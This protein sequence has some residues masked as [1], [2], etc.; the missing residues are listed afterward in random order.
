MK[1][2]R[3]ASNEIPAD[4]EVDVLMQTILKEW[5]S[6]PALPEAL[7]VSIIRR[8]IMQIL[9][10]QMLVQVDAP[11]NIC[12]DLHGQLHDL[13]AIFSTLG[14]P[15]QQPYLFLGDY[16][17]R[18]KH[19]IETIIVLLWHKIRHPERIYLL[20]GNHE[21]SSLTK[22]YGFFDDCKRKFSVRMWK[23]FVELF[24]CLPVAGL[25]EDAALCMHGGISPDLN[26]LDDINAIERPC[27][28]TDTGLLCDLLWADPEVGVAGW[29]KND[30]GVSYVFGENTL[31]EKLKELDLDMIIRAH[32]VMDHGYEFF[33]GRSLVTVFSASNYCG[34][35]TN[36][37]AVLK[38]D[39]NLKCSFQ[40]FKPKFVV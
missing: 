17:D 14:Q 38:M 40:V 19:G 26:T 35:F 24:N 22:Q 21:S 27:D 1:R 29:A 12:G 18:G 25:V 8:A 5:R 20:R 7:V 16:V 9:S 6:P 34:E 10:E 4:D 15:P 39:A 32:Q 13:A 31:K 36:C 11:V 30:R 28:V 3:Q 33:A 23:M 2:D 37:G